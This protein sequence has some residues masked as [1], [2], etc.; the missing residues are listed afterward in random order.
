MMEI[1]PNQTGPIQPVLQL[2]DGT[3]V[4][5]TNAGGSYTW[6]G[7]YMAKF[8]SSG[9]VAG[10]Q[11]GYGPPQMA[12]AD[13]GVV[14][15][16][17]TFFDSNLNVTSAVWSLPTYSW[18][19]AYQLGSIDS[20]VPAS[21][22]ASMI[23]TTYAAVPGGNLTGNGFALA[24]H[25]FGLVFCNTGAGG[26]GSCPSNIQITNMSFSYL[27]SNVI[28]QDN[29]PTACD[30]STASPCDNNTAHPEWVNT[31]KVQALNAFEAAFTS[32]PAIV[33]GKYSPV[34]RYGGSNNPRF[35]HTIYVDGLWFEQGTGLSQIFN[36]DYSWVFYLKVLMAAE[37][38]LGSYGNSNDFIPP[39]TDSANMLKLM[40]ALG[41][42]IGNS[43]AHEIGWELSSA[44]NKYPV[45]N[46]DCNSNTCEGDQ[47]VYESEGADEWKFVDWHPPI[48]WQP[49]NQCKIAKYL[50]NS[51]SCK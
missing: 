51:D 21:D 26:D 39:F 31:I 36:P 18:K 10:V 44:T 20:V 30:F 22:L 27:P 46:M 4:G 40:T 49:T 32:L 24:H 15:Q 42:G 38:N 50:L 9:S 23:A 5:T 3:F 14:T 35:E 48:H 6:T 33:K 34:M 2:Q 43:A 45:I 41:K 37:M 47:Y 12:T 7:Q 1:A 19:S 16:D 13:G 25:S 11:S 29:Y 17:G 8:D 28:D